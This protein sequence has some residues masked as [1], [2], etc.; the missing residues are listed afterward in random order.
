MKKSQN[1]VIGI[2]GTG[3]IG[4]S[5]ALL[6]TGNGFKTYLYA[7]NKEEAK[8]GLERYRGFAGDLIANDLLTEEE[9]AACR[10][11]LHIVEGYDALAEVDLVFE[12]IV[13]NRDIK[14]SVYKTLNEKCKNLKA[15]AS[16]TS[17]ISAEDLVE[18]LSFEEK[19]LVAHP[20]NPP[21]LVRLVEVVKN[22]KTSAEALNLTLEVLSD[23]GREAV[24]LKKNAPGFIANR[25]HHALFREA[26]NIVEQGIADPEEV[27][28][29]LRNS[30]AQRYTSV[31]IFEHF[32]YCGLDMIMSI[33][34]NLYPDLCNA[35]QPQ[36][37]IKDAF[38]AGNL[39]CKTG[40]GVLDWTGKDSSDVRIRGSKPYYQ[41]LNWNL[42]NK[43]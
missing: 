32:D 15:I 9:F 13:E 23:C 34:T 30:F 1:H 2:I 37:L 24:V 21:H 42:P 14:Q 5:L 3:V 31:G 41:K 7:I 4:S 12:C 6:F 28:A 20:W 36:A 8:L 10:D 29:A 38:E 43:N 19:V 25:M 33:H 39:G 27:D 40:K 35:T 17:A 22:S 11:L 16:S 18:G 26:V